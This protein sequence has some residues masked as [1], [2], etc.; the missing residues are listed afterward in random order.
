MEQEKAFNVLFVL[1]GKMV[2]ISMI[3]PLLAAFLKRKALNRSLKF[4]LWYCIVVFITTFMIE[5]FIWA[6]TKYYESW[7]SF[8]IPW[9][10]ADTNFFS[11]FAYLYD[12]G[13]LGWY[14]VSV[15]PNK[16]IARFTKWVCTVALLMS[17]SNYF[18]IKG[19]YTYDSFSQ[20]LI[21]IFKFVIPLY[22]LWLIY[23]DEGKVPITKNPYFWICLG[24]LIPGMVGLFAEVVGEKLYGSDTILFYKLEIGSNVINI[25][26]QILF[27][28]GFYYAPY[29]EF[30]ESDE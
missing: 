22:S 28:I 9:H 16:N 5:I 24:L 14:F 20:T 29:T 3:L 18:F 13:L 25:I 30:L 27:A 7:K 11:V 8:L 2:T 17:L 6:A 23:N 10:L 19:Y 12:F 21:S 26:G 1:F 15:M 4:F